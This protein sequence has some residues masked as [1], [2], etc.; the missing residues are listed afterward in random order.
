[1][2]ED[3]GAEEVTMFEVLKHRAQWSQLAPSP[4]EV[5]PGSRPPSSSPSR[6]PA[7]W[8]RLARVLVT[9]TGSVVAFVL[10]GNLVIVLA[11]QFTAR[12]THLEAP[13]VPGVSNLVAVDH[14]LWRSA[15]PSPRAYDALAADG[16]RT[17]VDLRSGDGTADDPARLR[18]LGIDL[19]R[20]PVRD[21][22][23]PS[24]TEVD[25]F[26]RVVR[27]SPGRVLVH[28]GAGVGRT[29]TMVAAYR[30][31]EGL[32]DGDDAVRQ[33]LA[34]GPPS[35]EQLVFASRIDRGASRP[36]LAVVATSR[37]LDA[38]RRMWSRWG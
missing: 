28:C 6:A 27:S 36:P 25:Q 23:V 16:V 17:I 13:S 7:T 24:R 5:E 29:G 2:A 37:V 21:G 4:A 35:L 32:G 18:H 22:Q 20:I 34:V 1:M 15:A 11:W 30:A 31:A 12:S 19:V 10:L 9:A 14:H 26:L 38:P 8:R 33:N 3:P